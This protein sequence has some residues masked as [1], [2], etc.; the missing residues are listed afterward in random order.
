MQPPRVCVAAKPIE[1]AHSPDKVSIPHVCMTCDLVKARNKCDRNGIIKQVCHITASYRKYI[2]NI[3]R[4]EDTLVRDGADAAIGQCP[5]NNST[6][7][8]RDLDG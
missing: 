8:G 5:G 7:L 2:A 4:A 1:N 6:C 3:I